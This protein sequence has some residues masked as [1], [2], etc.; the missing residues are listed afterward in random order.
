[1][2]ILAAARAI[3][4]REGVAHTSFEAVARE[5]GLSKGGV[6]YNFPTK[7]GLMAA[8][9]KEMLA[10]HDA[11]E[12]G[13]PQDAQHRTLR[14]HLASLNGLDTAD[15]D[16]SMSILAVAAARAGRRSCAHRGRGDGRKPWSS[17]GRRP[18]TAGALA[19]VQ[20]TAER[21][22]DRHGI[23]HG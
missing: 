23:R 1:M 2:R 4:A 5:A 20:R 3:A 9:L 7:R 16:L 10:E 11:L 14:R 18:L 8:L 12:A 13:L 17:R 15:S 22:N 21:E 6:L 19:V